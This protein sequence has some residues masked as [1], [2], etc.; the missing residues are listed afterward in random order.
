MAAAGPLS[1]ELRAQLQ[2]IDCAALCDVGK[3]TIRVMDS[4][5]KRIGGLAG[6]FAFFVLF[7]GIRVRSIHTSHGRKHFLRSNVGWIF[8]DA[9]GVFCTESSRTPNARIKRVLDSESN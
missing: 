9:H 8:C 3:E 1:D 7:F 6:A 5:I 2:T 4:G